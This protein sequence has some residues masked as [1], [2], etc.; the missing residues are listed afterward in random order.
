MKISFI[1][2][3]IMLALA[4]CG[5]SDSKNE[6][7]LSFSGYEYIVKSTS[8]PVVTDGELTGEGSIAFV[9][10]LGSVSSNKNFKISMT[11]EDAGFVELK[12]FANA[13]LGASIGL[14][15]SRA[16]D[17]LLLVSSAENKVA[18]PIILKGLAVSGPLSLSIDVH[19]SETPAHVMLWS[20]SESSPTDD[21]SVFNSDADGEIPGNGAGTFW[22]LSL[23]SSSISAASTGDSVFT[24]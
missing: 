18:E 3:I 4:A 9:E 8:S 22:G 13:E 6:D 16:G 15:L 1:T 20:S 24:H 10:P 17:T 21:N 2:P 14:K 12:T 7:K 11:L 19:N 5:K 23:K